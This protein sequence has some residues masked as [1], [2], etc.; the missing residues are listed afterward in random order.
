LGVAWDDGLPPQVKQKWE[1]WVLELPS[2]EV[3]RLLRQLNIYMGSS[4]QIH[5]FTDASSEAY[6][7]V[8]YLRVD[9]GQSVS[10]SFLMGKSRVKPLRPITI[11]RME[12]AAAVV[13]VKMGVA[14]VHELKIEIS[15]VFYHTDSTSVLHFLNN[16]HSRFPIFIANRVHA[17]LELSSVSH[18]RYVPSELNP[19][20]I[21]SRGLSMHQPE[22]V[23][24]WLN[25]PQF[26]SGEE[27]TW[28][29]CPVELPCQSMVVSG[30]EKPPSREPFGELIAHFSS[31]SK[32]RKAVAVYHRVFEILKFRVDS[33]EVG[34]APL[35]CEDHVFSQ[36]NLINSETAIIKFVQSGYFGPEITALKSDQGVIARQ[37]SVYR[38]NP[39]L[40]CGILKV[41]GRLREASLPSG[42]THPIL[43]PKQGHVVTLIAR[44]FHER[45]AH[46]GRSPS[47]RTV[48]P[49]ICFP[50]V[51]LFL[52]QLLVV[53]PLFSFSHL[54]FFSFSSFL[55]DA[56]IESL[57]RSQHLC[58]VWHGP[59][60]HFADV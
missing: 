3:V 48:I 4:V 1:N 21:A 5:V 36:S 9:N 44:H 45:L 12:L 28:P 32:L 52:I 39:F 51:F 27:S 15:E 23:R 42:I 20:D 37:S 25:G 46:S 56:P 49:M 16:S 18:W 50:L 7:A 41:G 13:G 53:Y 31:W 55:F 30:E 59:N 29:A 24:K 54:F 38:L 40:S 35:P 57:I 60:M 14:L 33:K 17:I 19:A 58:W 22:Q 26:L 2:I 43:L 34:V 10:I 47:R 6:G 8:S 11:P